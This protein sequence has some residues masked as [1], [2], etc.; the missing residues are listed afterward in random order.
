LQPQWNSD[1]EFNKSL[2]FVYKLKIVFRK[3]R[4]WSS[5]LRCKIIT[6]FTKEMPLQ[7]ERYH[8]ANL[9]YTNELVPWY[10]LERHGELNQK[11]R[12]IRN[13]IQLDVS[14]SLT[15]PF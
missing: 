14:I 13:E 5:S 9:R 3:L 1:Y 12:T 15:R 7:N 6:W 4:N 11:V 8:N 2:N 10:H